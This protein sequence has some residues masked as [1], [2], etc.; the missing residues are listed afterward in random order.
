MYK[1]KWKIQIFFI[2]LLG[3]SRYAQNTRTGSRNIFHTRPDHSQK[4]PK[5]TF[6]QLLRIVD[7]KPI[8]VPCKH[9][10][11]AFFSEKKWLSFKKPIDVCCK[12]PRGAFFSEKKGFP[13]K[14]PI[15][16]SC[17]HPRGGRPGGGQGMAAS[18]HQ[19]GR[20]PASKLSIFIGRVFKN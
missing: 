6:F 3:A 14:K 8:Y 5:I 16:V 4:L 20:L 2:W 19:N 17:K 11:G 9:P 15:C 7:R 12:H 10:R 13:L 1:T 18:W